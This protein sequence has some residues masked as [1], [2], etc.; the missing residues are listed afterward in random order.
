[1]PTICPAP[2]T[3]FTMKV[4]PGRCFCMIFRNQPAIEIV[5]AARRGGDDIGDGLAFEEIGA[6]L[7]ERG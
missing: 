3:F 1:M 2:G 4:E 6:G 7:R 5:A